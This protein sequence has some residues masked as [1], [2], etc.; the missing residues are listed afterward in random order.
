MTSRHVNSITGRLSLRSPQRRSLEILDR[1]ME[2]ARPHK[3][4]D[5]KAALDIIRSEFPSVEDFGNRA[6]RAE[7][8]DRG[9]PFESG[10]LDVDIPTFTV[11]LGG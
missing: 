5:L 1:V 9:E 2:I 7:A 8:R 3:S 10:V 11:V 6:E 4:V